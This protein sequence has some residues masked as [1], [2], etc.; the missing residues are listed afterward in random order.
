MTKTTRVSVLAPL[1]IAFAIPAAAAGQ[2]VDAARS[3]AAL[4]IMDARVLGIG[5]RLAVANA[6]LCPDRAIATGIV[7]HGLSQ[8]GPDQRAAARAAFGLDRR[9][10]ILAIAPG[11]AAERAGLRE[12]DHLVSVGAEQLPDDLPGDSSSYSAVGR[13]TVQLEKGFQAGTVPVNLIRDGR[14]MSVQ[15]T[16]EQGCPSRFQVVV[17]NTFGGKADGNYV[18]LTSNLVDRVKDDGELAAVL[19][20]ELAHNILRHRVQLNEAG[21]SRG[22]L[23]YFGKNASSIKRTEIEADRLSVY[24]LDRAGFPAQAAEA[25]WRRFGP[26]HPWGPFGSPTHPGWRS[27]AQSLA[28]ETVE[29]SSQK[30]RGIERP[31]PDFVSL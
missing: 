7:L 5:H 6:D 31:L 14:S 18:Q 21:V 2:G 16:P 23:K 4:R 9:P 25:F 3:L 24:L 11:S 13:W 28:R 1:L 22:L 19:A 26:Q 20:H 30:E 15:V 29:L 8:Y 17:S 12:D 10:A 27:R